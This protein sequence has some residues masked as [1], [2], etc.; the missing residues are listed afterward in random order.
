MVR[1]KRPSS[2]FASGATIIPPPKQRPFA[3]TNDV[4]APSCIGPPSSDQRTGMSFQPTS[5]RR[6]A[7]AK[8]S[9]PPSSLVLELAIRT[10][11]APTPASATL[12][13]YRAAG[14]PFES[15]RSMRPTSTALA[16]PFSRGAQLRKSPISPTVRRRS[17]PVPR[18]R[19]P[20][21]APARTAR[22]ASPGRGSSKNPLT[23]SLMVPS[24][25]TATTSSAPS[26][27]A[28]RASSAACMGRSVNAW[29]CSPTAPRTAAWISSKCRP[30][31]PFAERGLTMTNAFTAPLLPRRRASARG[32]SRRPTLRARRRS[33]DWR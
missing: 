17:P 20:S 4:T 16:S 33:L 32:R 29:A 31:A 12:M 28:R 21:A 23:T 10:A 25:P 5:A 22:G 2:S 26:R 8:V 14:R 3:I 30:V 27:S 19:M 7:S 9:F 13:K 15:R 18:G 1:W 6:E 24:P 11:S